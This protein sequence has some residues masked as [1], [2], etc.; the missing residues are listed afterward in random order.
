MKKAKTISRSTRRKGNDDAKTVDEYIAVL[1]EPAR[2]TL[3][4]VRVMIR[5]AAPAEATE[6]FSYGIPAFKYN[7]SHKKAC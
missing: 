2:R 5:S 1:P 6:G 3:K 4:K 7:G